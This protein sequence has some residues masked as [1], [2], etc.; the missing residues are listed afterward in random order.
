MKFYRGYL[1]KN[2][3][4]LMCGLPNRNIIYVDKNVDIIKLMGLC[5]KQYLLF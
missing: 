4:A 1:N 3:S 5:K 2:C